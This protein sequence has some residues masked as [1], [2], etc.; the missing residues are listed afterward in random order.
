[1]TAGST[2]TGGVTVDLG[3]TVAQDT[4][5]GE[6][7]L[8]SI[9]NLIGSDFDDTLRGNTKDNVITGGLGRD[10]IHGG[11]GVDTASY[12]DATG[13]VRV[14]LSRVTYQDTI[15]AGRDRLVSI[16]NL[17]GS[18]YADTLIG[19]EESNTLNGGAGDDILRGLAGNDTLNGGAGFDI[20]SYS[21]VTTNLNLALAITTS[22]SAGA[23][24]RC[25]LISIV[26]PEGGSGNDKLTGNDAANLL[27]GGAGDDTL[28]GGA[29]DDLLRG[30]AGNDKLLGG[31]GKDTADYSDI[32]ASISVDL[33]KSTAQDT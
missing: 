8:I 26:G 23:A 13:G 21:V 22:Q 6:D 33:A 4:G 5:D 1:A 11:G 3:I 2:T 19:N 14:D 28:S 18:A 9:E 15:S 16:E 27:I 30:G 29:G 12:A 25:T 24:G 10:Y 32:R 20:A 7:T 31:A 17:V